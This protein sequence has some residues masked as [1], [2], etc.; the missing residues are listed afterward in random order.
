MRMTTNYHIRKF[1]DKVSKIGANKR[2]HTNNINALYNGSYEEYE[3]P[4]DFYA[5]EITLKGVR[6]A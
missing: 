4:A 5:Q 2:N 3:D 1:N 6:V